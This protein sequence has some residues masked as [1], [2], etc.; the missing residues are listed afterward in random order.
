MASKSFS[1]AGLLLIVCALCLSF[2]LVAD[3]AHAQESVAKGADKEIASKKGVAQSL[4]N[5]DIEEDKLPGKF[6]VGLG[7]GSC[8]AMVAVMKWL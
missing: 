4:G 1:W 2:A 7:L 8:I 3:T 6:E 5:K